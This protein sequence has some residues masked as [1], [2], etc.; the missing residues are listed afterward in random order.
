MVDTYTDVIRNEMANIATTLASITE[1]DG[2]V[3]PMQTCHLATTNVILLTCFATRYPS[4]DHPKFLKLVEFVKGHLTRSSV[5]NDVGAIFPF[6]RWFDI[7]F[8][9][10]SKLRAFVKE[11][12]DAPLQELIADARASDKPSMVKTVDQYKEQYKIDDWD[13]ICFFCECC[14]T[15]GFYTREILTFTKSRYHP[16]RHRYHR[17]HSDMGIGYSCKVS[18]NPGQDAS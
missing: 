13:I 10:D 8:R 4:S 5:M 6:L 18:R 12:R 2:S 1:R 16:C 17:C 3:D 7:I 14:A 11:Y 15:M 9:Q